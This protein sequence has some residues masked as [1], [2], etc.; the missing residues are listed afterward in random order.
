MKLGP[1]SIVVDI[2]A[3]VGTYSAQLCKEIRGKPSNFHL[4][5]PDPSNYAEIPKH[6]PGCNRYQY[7]IAGSCSEMTLFIAN[8]KKSAGTSQA[9]SLFK[10]FVDSKEWSKETRR[11]TVWAT[12]LDHFLEHYNIDHIDLLKI[13][14]EGGEFSIFDGPTEFLALT[15]HID[16]KIHGKAKCFLTEKM[17]GKKLHIAKLLEAHEFTVKEGTP[18]KKMARTKGH[19]SQLWSKHV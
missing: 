7:A 19:I 18:I 16:L 6:F 3:Y 10:P 12:T 11:I 17:Q 2:G 13:N 5:E 8:H 4:I 1:D 15:N 14:C 9:N